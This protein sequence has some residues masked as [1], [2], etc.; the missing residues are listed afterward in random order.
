MVTGIDKSQDAVDL[1]NENARLNKLKVTFKQSDWFSAL[2]QQ[3]FDLIVSNPPYIEND[4]AYLKQ[5][6]VRFEPASALTSGVE[7]L[8]DIQFI[9]A[10]SKQHMTKNAWLA[11]EHGYNQHL[12]VS[13]IFN[14]HSFTDVRTE[15]DLNDLPRVT[16]ARL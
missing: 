10:K 12:Q 16:L 1:A 4:N 6:D 2:T 14:Q 11:I 3:Q 15:Y 9:V 13:A 8:D 7:G 5:G